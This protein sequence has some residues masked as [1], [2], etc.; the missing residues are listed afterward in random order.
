MSTTSTGPENTESYTKMSV[1]E[2]EAIGAHCQMTFCRQ[3]DF[4]PFK[5]ESCHGSFC[6]DHRTETA[7]SCPKAGAWLQR[8]AQQNA[9]ASRPAPRPTV[10]TH[11]QQ[12]AEV[13]CKT[14]IDTP[15]ITGVHCPKCNRRYCLKHRF[16]EDHDCKNLK[17]LGARPQLDVQREKG[18]AA[19]QKLREWGATKASSISL[20]S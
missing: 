12:C 19:L 18:L 3:L 16:R 5:C 20:P 7:H 4:L 13:A 1:G 8:R 10:L 11:E 2:V 6:L 17:P 9:A 14:L 15:L